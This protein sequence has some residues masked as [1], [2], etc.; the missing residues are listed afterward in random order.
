[1]LQ[2]ATVYLNGQFISKDR[3]CISPDDRGFYFGD[4]VY[5]VIKYYKGHPF[6]FEEHM[7]RLQNSLAGI[8]ID[9]RK[10]GEFPGIC[11]ALIN[12]NQLNDEYAGV[13]IQITRGVSTRIHRLPGKDVRPT[14]YARAFTLLPYREEMNKG[15]RILSRQDIRWLRCDIKSVTL[16]PNTLLFEDAAQQGAFECMLIRDGMVTEATHSNLLAVRAGKIH[17]HPDSNLILPG[18]TKAVVIRFCKTFNIQVIEEPIPTTDIG[19]YDEWILTGTGS[20]IV[21]VI[22][23]DDRIIGD[24]TPGPVTRLLQKEFFKITYEKLAG[25]KIVMSDE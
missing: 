1:M 4:G 11:K 5:E 23:V 24:G 25:E 17:T 18:I 2:P 12:A 20:E 14:V 9:Y 16:L 6:C 7:N 13:Y 22:Q 19:L 21:P 15:V 10:T 3:A 8:R